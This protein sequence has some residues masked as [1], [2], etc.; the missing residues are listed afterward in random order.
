LG[1]VRGTA[2]EILAPGENGHMSRPSFSPPRSSVFFPSHHV[3]IT[4][5]CACALVQRIGIA[6]IYS[7]KPAIDTN[8]FQ[9]L[10]CARLNTGHRIDKKG[11]EKKEKEKKR[12]EVVFAPP[13][14]K[15]Y[16]RQ[17][18]SHSRYFFC[19]SSTQ[20]KNGHSTEVVVRAGATCFSEQRDGR[21]NFFR[22]SVPRPLSWAIQNGQRKNDRHGRQ[23]W[24][25]LRAF[26]GSSVLVFAAGNRQPCQPC[27]L[28]AMADVPNG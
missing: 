25:R 20:V 15:D 9:W 5:R 26:V 11:P 14:A 8:H 16:D 22:L 19:S 2:I 27:R 12:R 7:G 1:A 4:R 17:G 6:A 3:N 23:W 18:P 21:T 10:H 28:S 13:L 24:Q